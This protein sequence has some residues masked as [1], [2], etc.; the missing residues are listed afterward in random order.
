M[1]HNSL[2]SCINMNKNN[3]LGWLCQLLLTNSVAYWLTFHFVNSYCTKMFRKKSQLAKM[4]DRLNKV[5]K[6]VLSQVL[7]T[8]VAPIKVML[9][10]SNT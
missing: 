7:T 6:S 2:K 1:C 4:L 3:L 5:A 8:S 9:C 10:S